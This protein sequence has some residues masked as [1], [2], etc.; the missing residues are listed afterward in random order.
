MRWIIF[1]KIHVK[2]FGSVWLYQHRQQSY[3]TKIRFV[4][5]CCKIIQATA[6]QWSQQ[7]DNKSIVVIKSMIYLIQFI[8]TLGFSLTCTKGLHEL[9]NVSLWAV[10]LDL[11]LNKSHLT[12]ISMAHR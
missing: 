8:K 11:E 7:I 2:I 6:F 5:Q 4:I 1:K 10:Y 3:K 12:N 9:T